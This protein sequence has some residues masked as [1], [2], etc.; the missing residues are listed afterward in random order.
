MLMCISQYI[1][2]L[3]GIFTECMS[4][5]L[6]LGHP[7][8]FYP[9]NR[10]FRRISTSCV[11]SLF[12]RSEPMRNS[13]R[14][15]TNPFQRSLP[16]AEPPSVRVQCP[17]SEPVP[18]GEHEGLIPVILS[19]IQPHLLGLLAGGSHGEKGNFYF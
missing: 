19:P 18:G 1:Y 16:Q 9:L 13:W 5:N 7:K 14:K 10:I 4:E 15:S 8:H 2:I 6:F 3:W 11:N 12:W 17:P